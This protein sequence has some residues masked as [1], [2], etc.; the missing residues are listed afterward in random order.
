MYIDF[1]NVLYII[2][3]YF[4]LL[5]IYWIVISFNLIIEMI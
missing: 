5:F 2:L 4:Y 3:Y 1:N